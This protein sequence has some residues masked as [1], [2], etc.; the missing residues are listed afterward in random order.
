MPRR[1]TRRRPH[2]PA[3]FGS[4]R[5][6]FTLAHVCVDVDTV[7]RRRARPRTNIVAELARSSPFVFVAPRKNVTTVERGAKRVACALSAAAGGATS[8]PTRLG[9]GTRPRRGCWP[10]QQPQRSLRAA[11]RAEIS[12]QNSQRARISNQY[13][14]PVE[15]RN[16]E[17]THIPL[18]RRRTRAAARASALTRHN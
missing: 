4:N 11:Q 13:S 16:L 18:L 10:R 5:N 12:N 14:Q 1:M 7:G 6:V 8:T 9:R 15:I 2:R 3:I 17:S